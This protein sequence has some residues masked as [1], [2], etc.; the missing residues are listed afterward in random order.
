MILITCTDVQR[1]E[2]KP[3]YTV[4]ICDV[5]SPNN[6]HSYDCVFFKQGPE[7]E[8]LLKEADKK[9]KRLLKKEEK[10]YE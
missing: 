8:P 5:D 3:L 2:G 9:A 4:K 6:F 7:L 10:N 1:W